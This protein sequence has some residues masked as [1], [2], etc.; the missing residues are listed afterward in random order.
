MDRVYR[1]VMWSGGCVE[2]Q[3]SRDSD[4]CR[5]MSNVTNDNY[6]IITINEGCVVLVVYWSH[7]LLTTKSIQMYLYI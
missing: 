4:G 2:W 3:E 5:W 1:S 7:P 6:W